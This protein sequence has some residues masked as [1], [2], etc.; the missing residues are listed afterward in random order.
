MHPAQSSYR[1]YLGSEMLYT[2]TG[3]LPLQLGAGLHNRQTTD[4]QNTNDML[5]P[6]NLSTDPA[7][8]C[9]LSP[10]LLTL[11]TLLPGATTLIW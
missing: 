6:I 5:L 9:V 11:M 7:S 8:G 3:H 2:R 1:V 4:G 10:L